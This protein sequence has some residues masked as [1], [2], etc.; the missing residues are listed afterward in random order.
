MHY[1]RIFVLDDG[2]LVQ[3]G[4]PKEL[5]YSKGPFSKMIGKKLGEIKRL[6][7]TLDGKSSDE[8]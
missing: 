6:L 2:E 7:E 4:S 8:C 5:V 3:H 1:D